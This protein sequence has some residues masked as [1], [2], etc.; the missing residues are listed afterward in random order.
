MLSVCI[1]CWVC[2]LSVVLLLAWSFRKSDC[3][4]GCDEIT[5]NKL[6][7]T[8]PQNDV[9]G[10]VYWTAKHSKF[11]GVVGGGTTEKEA[12][13]D[14]KENLRIYIEYLEGRNTR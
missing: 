12:V 10:D 8:C 1:I 11:D 7:H 13:E 2:I 9:D 5:C 3:T 6:I 14:L 4:I